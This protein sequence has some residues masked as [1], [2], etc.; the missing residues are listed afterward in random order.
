MDRSNI[1]YTRDLVLIGGGHT[2]ALVLKKWAMKPLP[3]AR[4]TLINP[5]PMAPYSGMLPG[6]VAGHY[7]KSAMEIDLVQ[8][9]RHAGAR[10]VLG[11]AHNIDRISRMIQ[12]EGHPDIAYDVTSIDIGIT[13]SMPDLPGFA[14]HA[15]PAKPLSHF[16]SAWECFRKGNGPAKLIIIGGGVAGAEL[17][18]AMAHAMKSD[19]RNVTIKLLD[20]GHAFSSLGR[21]ASDRLR[22]HL[23]HNGIELLEGVRAVRILSDRVIMEKGVEVQADFITGTA[24]AC[25][26][27]WL[28]STGLTDDSGFIP[29]DP[30]LRSTDPLVFATG[31]CALM[32]D[33]P[34]P[35]A[36]VFAVRQSPVLFDNL[37]RALTETGGM[38]AYHPQKDYLKLISLGPKS[39][40]GERFGLAFSGPWVWRWKD[41]IDR[42]FMGK[43]ADVKPPNTKHLPWPR[44][45]GSREAFSDK[46]MCGGCGA[47]IGP[48]SL[49]AAL[50]EIKT[51]GLGDDAAVLE[52]GKT[53]Q[54]ISTDHL[55]AIVE[56]PITMAR[57]AAIHALGDIWAM[58]AEPQAAVASVILPRQSPKLAERSLSEIMQA[59]AQTFRLA[60]AEIVGGHSTL[61]EELVIGFTV[62]GLC[63]RK[64]IGI[65]GAKP[66]QKLLLTKPIG[67]GVI[68]AA[69][70]QGKAKGPDVAGALT[71]MV[72]PQQQAA[73]LLASASAMTDVTGF[74]LVGHLATICKESHVGAELWTDAVPLMPGALDLAEDGFRSSLF[75]ENTRGFSE[76]PANPRSDLMFDPQTGGG[77]LAA[78]DEDTAR[79]I[80]KLRNKG[81]E[82]A[83]I[84]QVTDRTGEVE[85]H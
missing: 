16:A 26:H 5:G 59:A 53:Q 3:G 24:G 23:S 44:A 71:W 51:P 50:T 14:E 29:V 80:S 66:G 15:V 36:G 34:R 85:I 60:G 61:G 46:Q 4:L 56:D 52:V 45:A 18:M 11:N 38:R 40:L 39:A 57:I 68:M 13:S 75:T 77:L 20:Q 83:V 7:E 82:A 12:V 48:E 63:P 43:F 33:S 41:R 17:A 6:F 67:S 1:P 65:S 78:I 2:H 54:V 28:K 27:D 32:K 55:R 42:R 9:A 31:D 10:L 76:R 47:K 64:P 73:R 84:G 69:H 70:M 81:Y 79:L 49:R 58:G 25:P 72:Q 62:T 21:E 30:R 35:K 74:G 37:R 8:L 19:G 22:Y